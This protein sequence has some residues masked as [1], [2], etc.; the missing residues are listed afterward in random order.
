MSGKLQAAFDSV[1]INIEVVDKKT[2]EMASTFDI[3]K[4]I[5]ERWDNLTEA[6]KQ[7]IGELAAGKN[8]ITNFNALLQNFDVALSATADAQNSAGS[9]AKENERVLECS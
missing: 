9:A 7:N 4:A 5:A 2:G 3:L 8:Q 6:Q 1:G